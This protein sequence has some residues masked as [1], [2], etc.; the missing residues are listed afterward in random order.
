MPMPATLLAVS[1]LLT[2]AVDRAAVPVVVDGT[3]AMEV[4]SL[5]DTLEKGL[6]ARRPEEFAF[7]AKVID[8]VEQGKLT[9]KLVRGTFR[10]AQRQDDHKPFP[11]FERAIK[12]RA[13]NEEN[14]DL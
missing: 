10:W 7:I 12:L 1:V 6:K 13:K 11:Y 3:V 9:E 4:S 8:L 2:V 5:K 14:V